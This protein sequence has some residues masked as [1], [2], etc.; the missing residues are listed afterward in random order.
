MSLPVEL[1]PNPLAM[2]PM[3][4]PLWSGNQETGRVMVTRVTMAREEELT[5]PYTQVSTHTRTLVM[6]RI[7]TRT[8]AVVTSTW[9]G[10]GSGWPR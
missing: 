8:E 5:I 1:R 9:C 10:G 7:N 2:K 4:L 6:T 3:T